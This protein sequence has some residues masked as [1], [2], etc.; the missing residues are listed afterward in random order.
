[1]PKVRIVA[2]YCS[3]GYQL[4]DDDARAEGELRVS[5]ALKSR[6]SE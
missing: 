2:D 5:T 3:T 4:L 1:M 6:L